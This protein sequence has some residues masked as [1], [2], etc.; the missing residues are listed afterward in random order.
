[1]CAMQLDKIAAKRVCPNSRRDE[2][3]GQFRNVCRAH[4]PRHQPPLIDRQ[5]ACP[6]NRPGRVTQSKICLPQ[7]AIATPGALHG[8]LAPGMSQLDAR[9]RAVVLHEIHH[10]LQRGSMII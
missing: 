8:C 10:G 5:G 1:M 6:I 9:Q 3:F 4:L 7:W 2:C